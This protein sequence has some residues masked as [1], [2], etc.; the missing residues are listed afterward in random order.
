MGGYVLPNENPFN[1]NTISSGINRS[2]FK[3]WRGNYWENRAKDFIN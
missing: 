2:E 3:S 1:L